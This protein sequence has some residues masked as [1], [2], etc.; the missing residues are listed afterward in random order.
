M[1]KETVLAVWDAGCAD[2]RIEAALRAWVHGHREASDKT[3]YAILTGSQWQSQV[4]LCKV[5]SHDGEVEHLCT[6]ED[7]HVEIRV[8]GNVDPRQVAIAGCASVAVLGCRVVCAAKRALA[9]D[10]VEKQGLTVVGPH[11]E[12]VCHGC[13]VGY[14]DDA[15]VRNR[16][17]L[18]L[19][20][21]CSAGVD[22]GGELKGGG[23][24][25]GG[26]GRHLDGIGVEVDRGVCVNKGQGLEDQ[27]AGGLGEH[28]GGA[29]VGKLVGDCVVGVVV[30][31][32]LDG[33]DV[34]VETEAES[35]GAKVGLCVDEAGCID[36]ARTS[37][38]EW[39]KVVAK[40]KRLEIS[41]NLSEKSKMKK[42]KVK[43]GEKSKK[44]KKKTYPTI[45]EF[46]VCTSLCWVFATN[47]STFAGLPPML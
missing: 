29:G 11:V 4:V 22:A 8:V 6:G 19:E 30:E 23:D 27:A 5:F 28:S 46:A 12:T 39:G 13:D 14:G 31:S 41:I 17:E 18:A 38:N 40:K 15:A 16:L 37:F 7:R 33:G 45:I 43:N 47:P 44:N 42:R 34:G 3:E 20:D 1:R 35:G 32:N 25:D 2:A 9:V 10:V 21:G 24:C 36:E 26:L